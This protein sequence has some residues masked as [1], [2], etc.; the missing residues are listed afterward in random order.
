MKNN[1]NNYSS[2]L[3]ERQYR[4]IYDYYSYKTLEEIKYQEDK[5][6]FSQIKE[7]IKNS[8]QKI[9][10]EEIN[11]KNA[12]LLFPTA[13]VYLNFFNFS[14]VIVKKSYYFNELI[15]TQFFRIL[16]VDTKFLSLEPKEFYSNLLK[17]FKSLFFLNY[18]PNIFFTKSCIFG[19]TYF[20][21]LYK[22]QFVE[23]LKFKDWIELLLLSGICTIPF[24]LYL[25]NILYKKYISPDLFQKSESSFKYMGVQRN[26]L[27]T[28][29]SFLENFVFM[30]GFFMTWRFFNQNEDRKNKKTLKKLDNYELFKET[31]DSNETLSRLKNIYIK[32]EYITEMDYMFPLFYTVAI[33]TVLFTPIEFCLNLMIGME[34]DTSFKIIYNK[35]TKNTQNVQDANFTGFI[36]NAFKSN[37]RMNLYRIFLQYGIT[38]YYFFSNF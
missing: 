35:F 27:V 9:L 32:D 29:K 31:L 20:H 23:E 2:Y 11:K 25:E 34:K 37:L 28:L 7:K 36:M 14:D 24:S 16:N 6:Y 5:N 30:S 15:K 22:F 13:N 17:T 18:N 4:L 1:T 8:L 10:P 21:F 19:L 12:I 38:T 3:S 26:L 33:T